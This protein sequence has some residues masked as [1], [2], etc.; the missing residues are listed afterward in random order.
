MSWGRERFKKAYNRAGDKFK[1]RNERAQEDNLSYWDVWAE[2]HQ[3]YL[4]EMNPTVKE[5]AVG[6]LLTMLVKLKIRYTRDLLNSW[7]W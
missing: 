5:I 3:E 2:Q 1:E 6:R 7:Y 4:D